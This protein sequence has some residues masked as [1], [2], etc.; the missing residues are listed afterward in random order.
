MNRDNVEA[1]SPVPN[2]LKGDML[3]GIK[4]IAAFL[5]LTERQ[6]YHL[7]ASGR[8]EGCFQMGRIW[9]ARRSTLLGHLRRR[10]GAA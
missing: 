2:T 9:C 10:E 4:E 7:V 8:L 5:D 6:T 1:L 3:R